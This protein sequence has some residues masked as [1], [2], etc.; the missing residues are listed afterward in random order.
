MQTHQ[1]NHTKGQQQEQTG[2]A[3]EAVV[4]QTFPIANGLWQKQLVELS[5]SQT[6]AHEGL[7]ARL[8]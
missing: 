5:K 2:S 6:T 1:I 3:T 7:F 8:L 4:S